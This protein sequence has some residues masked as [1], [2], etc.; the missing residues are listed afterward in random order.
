MGSLL[1]SVRRVSLTQTILGTTLA[2]LSTAPRFA[3]REC[4]QNALGYD[5]PIEQA[6]LGMKI[7]LEILANS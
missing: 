7:G 1:L 3:K 5:A 4:V 2:I 6:V